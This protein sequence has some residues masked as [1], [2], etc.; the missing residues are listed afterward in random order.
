MI[1]RM[2]SVIRQKGLRYLFIGGFNTFFGYAFGVALYY[3]LEEWLHIA[4][5]SIICNIICIT[6]SYI[7]YKFF[8]FQTRGHYL[9]EYLKFYIVYG[10]SALLGTVGLWILVDFCDVPFWL[11]SLLIMAL[12]VIISFFGHN[13][14]TFHQKRQT[15]A[16]IVGE[17]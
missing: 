9:I 2:L 15:V 6:F 14:F 10:G 8:V 7:T 11:A 5:I 1:D 13:L 16:Q 17:I 4:V 3:S 12:G